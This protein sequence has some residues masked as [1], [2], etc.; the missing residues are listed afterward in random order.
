MWKSL[1]V[2]YK[3]GLSHFTMSDN[4]SSNFIEFC[5]GQYKIYYMQKH[6]VSM[7]DLVSTV[8]ADLPEDVRM[9][10]NLN[11]QLLNKA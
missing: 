4:N 2:E 1:N 10:S 5:H 9:E 6:L 7:P 8:V 3:A 11:N